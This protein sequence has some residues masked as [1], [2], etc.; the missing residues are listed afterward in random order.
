MRA[1]EDQREKKNRVKEFKDELKIMIQNRISLS[2]IEDSQIIEE[3]YENP[4][5]DLTSDG[6]R[7]NYIPL[8][9]TNLKQKNM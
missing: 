1:E 8:V 7:E 2:N 4:M 5:G 6:H 3:G 9:T